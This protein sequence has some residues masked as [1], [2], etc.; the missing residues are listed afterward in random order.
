MGNIL[1]HW[2]LRGKER[3]NLVVFF[4]STMMHNINKKQSNNRNHF[5]DE[6]CRGSN[7]GIAVG[8][9]IPGQDD[10]DTTGL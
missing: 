5:Y 6:V 7:N 9:S 1:T 8:P 10:S 2:G 3:L 4:P